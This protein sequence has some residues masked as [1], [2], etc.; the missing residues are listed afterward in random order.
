MYKIHKQLVHNSLKKPLFLA[1]FF[2][3]RTLKNTFNKLVQSTEN[4]EQ[5]ADFHNRATFVQ[6]LQGN[7]E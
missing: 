3:S 2:L 6:I 4:A 5:I 7:S 1:Q